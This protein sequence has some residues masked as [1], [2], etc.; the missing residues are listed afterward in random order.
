M[1]VVIT[2]AGDPT[3]W[4]TESY[5]DANEL[6]AELASGPVN[7]EV[8]YPVKGN[9]LISKGA[10]LAI[11]DVPPSVSWIPSGAQAPV[12][13]LYVQAGPAADFSGYTLPVGTNLA[14]LESQITA[15]MHG[16]NEIKVL[17]SSATGSGV[18]ILNGASLTFAVVCPPPAP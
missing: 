1:Y 13:T 18:A 5:T 9:L 3:S 17:V 7:V 11:L 8:F 14:D 10:S 4:W 15:A 16:R 6:V 12:A 2:I